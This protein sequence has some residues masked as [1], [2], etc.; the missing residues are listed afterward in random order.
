MGYRIDGFEEDG[1]YHVFT[2]GV[3]KR[4]I[5]LDYNDRIRF[6]LLLLHCLPN[7]SILSFSHAQKLK[8]KP[9]LTNPG[10][11]LVDILAYCLMDNHVHLL[12]RE[13]VNGGVSKYIQRTLNSYAKYFN[14]RHDRTGVLFGGRFRSVPVISDEQLLHVSRYIHL[15][16]SEAN[17]TKDP[18]TYPWSSLG[19][20]VGDSKE[21][22]SHA[23]FI[24]GVMGG[25]YREFVLDHIDYGQTCAAYPELLIDDE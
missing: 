10:E 3:E 12:L 16:P 8:Q 18:F 5:F 2:R 22:F 21:K 17:I 20:Y 6:R 14:M 13:N 23:D 9:E 19:Q 11:G 25:G 24:L 7:R 1:I 4:K 15:N